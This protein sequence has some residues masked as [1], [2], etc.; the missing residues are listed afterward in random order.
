MPWFGCRQVQIEATAGDSVNLT[1]DDESSITF[2][3]VDFKAHEVLLRASASRGD[4][5][6]ASLV[7]AHFLD[8]LDDVR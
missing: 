6:R 3:N 1:F 2:S 7:T 5:D 4:D 8:A